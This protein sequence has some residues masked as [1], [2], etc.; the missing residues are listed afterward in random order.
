MPL[1]RESQLQ[2]QE[3]PKKDEP[4]GL[5]RKETTSRP[6]GA[7]DIVRVRGRTIAGDRD[8]KEEN[9]LEKSGH[10]NA[11]QRYR[12]REHNENENDGGSYFQTTAED[13]HIAHH[14]YFL[15]EDLR[16]IVQE[17]ISIQLGLS[18]KHT[19]DS[20]RL[21]ILNRKY[22]L[23]EQKWCE[24]LL[25]YGGLIPNGICIRRLM[26]IVLL[27]MAVVPVD[28]DVVIFAN[29]LLNESLELDIALLNVA[30]VAKLEGLKFLKKT[31]R[32]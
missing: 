23:L 9:R 21:E 16:E 5:S 6:A 32:R 27:G 20:E 13:P 30:V 2:P 4:N 12:L 26:K 25:I 19:K 24:E 22:W 17:E 15:E 29:L 18:N 3:I 28:V 7:T 10:I 11:L 8:D 31:R 14:L 1:R